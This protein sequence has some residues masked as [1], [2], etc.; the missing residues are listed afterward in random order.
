MTQLE[1]TVKMQFVRIAN[2][3]DKA[4]K[5]LWTIQ[6]T[7]KRNGEEMAERAEIRVILSVLGKLCRASEENHKFHLW[8][9]TTYRTQI[10][11][12][13]ATFTLFSDDDK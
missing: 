9:V 6:R 10:H 7:N 2:I 3:S 12:L 8:Q 5:L 13:G 4:R 11:E 1:S